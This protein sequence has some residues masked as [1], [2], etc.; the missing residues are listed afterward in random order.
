M[1][2][3]SERLSIERERKATRPLDLLVDTRTRLRTR[4]RSLTDDPTCVHFFQ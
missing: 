1:H 4:Q 2:I 3:D